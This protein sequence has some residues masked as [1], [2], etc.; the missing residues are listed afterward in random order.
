[1]KDTHT[2]ECLIGLMPNP[3]PPLSWFIFKR[4]EVRC[5]AKQEMKVY[6]CVVACIHEDDRN[7]HMCASAALSRLKPTETD[8]TLFPLR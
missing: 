8:V 1:M 5:H 6:V 4:K 2:S 7:K 3:R